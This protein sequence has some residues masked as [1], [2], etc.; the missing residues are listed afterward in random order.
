[1]RTRTAAIL[2]MQLGFLFFMGGYYVG[3][4]QCRDTCKRDAIRAGVAYYVVNPTNGITTF[5]FVTNRV[6][7]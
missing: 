4:T 5:T 6:E 1:M 2:F 7:K 3:W